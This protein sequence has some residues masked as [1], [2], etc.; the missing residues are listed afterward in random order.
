[1]SGNYPA[2]L[3]RRAEAMLRLAERLLSE[4]EYD[5]AVLNAEYAVQLYI[6]SILY[7]LSGEEWRGH[8]V[9]TLLGALALIAKESGLDKA[10][11]EIYDFV[12]GKRRVLA[13][14]DE[15]H[16]RAIYG[17]FE[18]S[19][20]QAE[21]IINIAKHIIKL[22]KETIEEVLRRGLESSD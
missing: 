3:K 17:I 14:L 5:L 4:G 19:E 11:E 7:R 9:R 12:R 8:S 21:V 22:V 18:Y 1:M 2:L 10:A 6:K 13:E 15:A 16:V 20:K